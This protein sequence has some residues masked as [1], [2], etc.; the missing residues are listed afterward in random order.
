MKSPADID[1][2]DAKK[3][4]RNVESKV[5][6]IPAMSQCQNQ[7]I[8]SIWLAQGLGDRRTLAQQFLTFFGIDVP[9]VASTSKLEKTNF[10]DY[11]LKGVEIGKFKS[12]TD[13]TQYKCTEMTLTDNS[14]TDS[15]THI[16]VANRS[17]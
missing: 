14:P 2:D 6:Y 3:G 17:K 5:Q 4:E 12:Q 10:W 7:K 13:S 16:G 11:V 1:N 8:K 15:T 9:T